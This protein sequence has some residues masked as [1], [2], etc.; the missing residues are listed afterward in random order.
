MKK[1]HILIYNEWIGENIQ[2]WIHTTAIYNKLVSEGLE[3][4]DSEGPILKLIIRL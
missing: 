1:L 4:L 2:E 3:I